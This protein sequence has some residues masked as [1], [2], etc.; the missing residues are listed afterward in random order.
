MNH[1][2]DNPAG[3]Q[4]RA[5]IAMDQL[6]IAVEKSGYPL[7]TEVNELLRPSFSAQEEW[8]YVDRDSGELR[9]IDIR[10]DMCLHSWDDPQP[11]VRPQLTLLV[12]C[13]QSQLPYVFFESTA[14]QALHDHPKIHGLHKPTIT[15]SSDDDPSTWTLTIIHALD[16]A[17]HPFQKAPIYCSTF[18]KVVRKGTDIELS[19]TDAYSGLV[20]PLIKSLEHLSSA[21]RPPKTAWYFDAHLSV[22]V[23][24]L[25]A[26]MVVA[27]RQKGDTGLELVP[28]VRILRH[29]YSANGEFGERDRVWAIDIV[30]KD[31][32]DGYITTHL[33][34][35]A[36]DFAARVLAHTTE[37]AT[38]HAFAAGMGADCWQG[39]ES[40]LR[41]SQLGS[42]V[43]RA[44]AVGQH[45]LKS[46]KGKTKRNRPGN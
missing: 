16:L 21:E 18:S 22:A 11:R 41:P 46:S 28:W 32:L 6:R 12:E 10:A 42:V 13:K 44:R 26:P 4:L 43:R 2:Q 23:G 36:K 3:N 29:E 14:P 38:G 9:S 34:P 5:G 8:C 1:H 37:I 17:E 24:V 7:Q 45:L 39:F 30:H 27:R 35:F 20:L 33:V 15:I 25:D 31:Y 19:G 40:R